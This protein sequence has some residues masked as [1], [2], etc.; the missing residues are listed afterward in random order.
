MGTPEV[1]EARA[2]VLRQQWRDKDTKDWVRVNK[3]KKAE[4]GE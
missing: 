2:G 1:R 4:G 3:G